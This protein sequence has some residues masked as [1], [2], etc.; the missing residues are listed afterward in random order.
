MAEAHGRADTET[1]LRALERLPPRQVSHHGAA[2]HELD[3]DALLARH[4]AVALVDGLAHPCV[5]GAD[6][7]SWAA[8]HPGLAWSRSSGARPHWRR[9]WPGTSWWP[10]SRPYRHPLTWTRCWWVRR[11]GIAAPWPVHRAA[12]QPGQCPREVRTPTPGH[13][14]GA[15]APPRR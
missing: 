11:A 14:D 7:G 10:S 13:R 5:P 8:P 4:P 9:N 1:M 2:F 6:P 3:V 12:G 15:G